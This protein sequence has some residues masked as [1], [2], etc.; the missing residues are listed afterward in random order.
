[1]PLPPPRPSGSIEAKSDGVK[2]VPSTDKMATLRAYLKAQGLCYICAKKWSHNHK[3]ANS[4][5]L[6]AVQEVFAHLQD[7][8]DSVSAD[9][10]DVESP[11]RSELM[12]V[13]LL[14]LQGVESVGTMRILGYVQGFEV[15]ILVDSGSSVSFISSKL[16]TGLSGLHS[17]PTPLKV[18]VAS[19]GVLHCDSIV[20]Q[21]EWFTQ[22]YTFRTD[23][24]VLPLTSYDMILGIDWLATHSPMTVDWCNR[25]LTISAH[26]QSI[27]LC[28]IKPALNTCAL[29]TPRQMQAFG[30]RHA[31]AHLVQLCELS[32]PVT[33][34]QIPEVVQK[35]LQDYAT[36]F[37]EPTGLPPSRPY[38]HTIPL[39]HGAQPM[40]V[41]PY[42]YTPAQKDEIESQV[43]DILTKGIIWP[44]AV[45]SLLQ[46]F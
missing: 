6:H 30:Y 12:V 21:C 46:C 15:L 40:N 23:L 9:I 20:T 45:H 1:M 25:V 28:G 42:R 44:S 17:L 3:C 7:P 32:T 18:Q 34:E 11:A 14:A 33:I 36:V 39:I 35:V 2:A 43:Q 13:S 29:A 8:Q 16:A 19:G 26:R 37:D 24:R 5:Q 31:V 41:R 38:D 4:V 10:L 27:T 22:G